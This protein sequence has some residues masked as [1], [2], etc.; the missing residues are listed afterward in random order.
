MLAKAM[1]YRAFV[2]GVFFAGWLVAQP[3]LA[4][5]VIGGG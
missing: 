2:L 1:R 3:W 4:E 5:G